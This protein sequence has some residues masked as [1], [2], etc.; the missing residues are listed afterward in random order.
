MDS[1]ACN[2]DPTSAIDDSSCAYPSS[3]ATTITAC[4]SL[5]WNGTTYDQSGT[6]SYSE[7]SISS[8]NYS[9]SFDGQ[10]D[11]VELNILTPFNSSESISI[12]TYLKWSG[13]NGVTD[14]QYIVLFAQNGPGN[15]SLTINN[16]GVLKGGFLQCNCSADSDEYLYTDT[17]Q[18]DIWYHVLYSYDVLNGDIKLF[19]DGIEVDQGNYPFS[20]YYN[21]NNTPSRIGNYHFN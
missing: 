1:L 12:E 14:H 16:D 21:V 18:Q 2:Y 15:A 9:I 8:N 5:V 7:S 11:Y 20:S 6:Y 17:L 19:L 4:D 13:P 3:S 10:D